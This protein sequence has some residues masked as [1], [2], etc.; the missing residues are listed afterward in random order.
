MSLYDEH[1]RMRKSMDQ[2][3]YSDSL[4]A[5]ADVVM[6]K[7]ID[8]AMNN[9]RKAATDAIGDILKYYHIKK[10][11]IPEELTDMNDILEYVLRPHGI[12]WRTVKLERKWYKEAMGAML[13]TRKDTGDIV[14]LLPI[15]VDHYRIID[16]KNNENIVLK[17]KT[18]DILDP[19]AIVFYRSFPLKKMSIKNLLGF[20]IKQ[21]SLSDIIFL[22]LA[23]LAVTLLGLIPPWIN[24]IMFS[25]VLISGSN[26]LLAG[27]SI[28]L[29]CATIST[30]M[31]RSIQSLMT[32]RI[33]TKLDATVHSASM[34]R[35][36]SLP[37]EFFRDYSVGELAQRFS[38]MAQICRDL[39]TSLFSVGISAIMSIVY[40][41]QIS[42]FAP[43]LL[44][45]AIVNICLTLI[46]SII[47]VLLQMSVS[48][49]TMKEESI[50]NGLSYQMISGIQ[51]IKLSGSE[52][53][54]FAKW[55]KQ[56]TRVAKLEYDPPFFLK[57]SPVLVLAISQFGYLAIDI[58][59]V[60]HGVTQAD[61][62]SFCAA[63]GSLFSAFMALA[64]VT[65]TLAGIPSMLEMVKP[66][67]EAEPEISQDKEVVQ[68]LSGNIEFNN[69]SF[70]YDENDRKILDNMSFRIHAGEYVAIVGKSG[71]G[72]STLVRILLG[73]EKPQKGAVYFSNRDM[74]SIDLRSLRRNIGTV[75]QNGKMLTGDIFSNIVISAPRLTIDDAWE[76]AELAGIADDIRSM[77][78]G[79]RTQISEGEGGISG[80]QR[81]RI[82]IARA[83][84]PKPSIL[85]LDEATSALDN[86]TQKKV[87]EA[88][89][90][91]NC[92]RIVIAHR[93]STIKNCD[94]IL[95]MDGGKIIEDGKY[96]ELMKK[97]GFFAELVKRQQVDMA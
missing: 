59:A 63:Y 73:F 39:V 64:D 36:L 15:G 51:K 56:Y 23:A 28:L 82:L 90:A 53:R 10:K 4:Q 25:D 49:R 21:A 48:K 87:S 66:I 14:A 88:M 8:E 76:A 30:A 13:G 91:L 9:D 19:E 50:E 31:F 38:Y 16:R 65:Y 35:G 20:I 40:F 26:K 58:V 69:V 81:Q 43:S 7:S 42:K 94:R 61:F 70:S 85:I 32:A 18:E 24:K 74:N 67:M 11:D 77:P 83:I 92:T 60:D 41:I 62:Y 3:V 55:G 27:A 79:M 37:A 89:D 6:G 22:I 52:K 71:C 46:V 78:M 29:I 34:M 33:S 72:K 47:T 93:L 95:V 96:D 75:L 45:C 86:V 44:A 17:K 84:A 80:G 57:I 1:I 97:N 2:E 5:M 68:K 54:A 12:M